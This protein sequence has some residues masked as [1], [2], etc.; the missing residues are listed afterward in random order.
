MGESDL[1]HLL[2]SVHTQQDCG[3]AGEPL[4]TYCGSLIREQS[5]IIQ[6]GANKHVDTFSETGCSIGGEILIK[7]KSQIPYYGAG[8][9]SNATHNSFFIR[10]CL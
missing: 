4:Q 3:S 7:G 8:G 6:P 9:Q 10:Y 2:V 1:L 5:I